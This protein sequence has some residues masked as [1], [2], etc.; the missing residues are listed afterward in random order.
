MNQPVKATPSKIC[1]ALSIVLFGIDDREKPQAAR[2]PEKLSDLA[3][4][5]GEQLK[6][7]VLKV[8]T[9]EAT[10]VAALL[11]VGRI[12]ANGTGVVPYV[13]Q[14]LYDMLIDLV[15]PGQRTPGLGLPP[16]WKEI[17]VNDLVIAFEDKVWGWWE[18]VV[19]ERTGDMLKLRWR[20]FP[21]QPPVARH[22]NAVALLNPTIP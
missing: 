15:G 13:K 4:K 8:T 21:K 16:S 1:P 10:K 11:P 19:I 18:A 22:R 2:F 14:N 7:N 20:D 12:N 9:S 5:A 3:I 17:G 6:L